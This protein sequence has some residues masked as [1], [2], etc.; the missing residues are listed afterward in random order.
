MSAMRATVQAKERW[1]F[2]LLKEV[3]RTTQKRKSQTI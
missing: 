2:V 3:F 1:A